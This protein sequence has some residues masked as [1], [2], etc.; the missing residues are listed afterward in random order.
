MVAIRRQAEAPEPKRSLAESIKALLGLDVVE[1]PKP[2]P[3]KKTTCVGGQSLYQFIYPRNYAPHTAQKKAHGPQNRAPLPDVPGE[4]VEDRARREHLRPKPIRF[5]VLCCGRR[6]GKT[7][8]SAA[9]FVAN[10]VADIEDKLLG[11]GRWQGHPH[12]P[13]VRT[14]GKDPEPFLRYF[15]ISPTHALNDEPK[16]ALRKYFGHKDDTE[17]GLIVEQLEKPSVW[18]LKGGVR[19]DFLSADRPLLNVSHGYHGGWLDECARIKADLWENNLR[20][21]L[22][23]HNGWAI[24]S[25][26]PLGRNWFWE[27]IWAHGDRRAAELLARMRGVEAEQILDEAQFAC[28]SWTTADNDAIPGLKAEMELARRQLSDANFRRNYLADFEAFEGQCFDLDAD[29]MAPR[30]QPGMAWRA[31]YGGFDPGMRHRAAFSIAVELPR[32]KGTRGGWSEID[33]DSA[34]GVLPYGDE[35]WARRDRGDRSTW[36]NRAYH[37]LKAVVG[38]RWTDVPIYM[39]ADAAALAIGQEWERYG[40]R[41]EHAFQEHEPAV[42]WMQTALKNRRF[43]LRTEVQWTCMTTLRFPGPGEKSTKLWIDKN[44]DE[45]DALR[46]AL[47]EPISKGFSPLADG[48]PLAALGWQRH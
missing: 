19:I 14:P 18:W 46:Y 11:R 12:E 15:V 36:A 10:I 17:P 34:S 29:H 48:A 32:G 28:V 22:S 7:Q 1:R 33:T 16:I 35:A 47:T 5:L 42:T 43:T 38:D 20:A 30:W 41:I 9:Q 2:D 23:D 31:I 26:T 25:T 21:A 37:A 6:G 24:F 39:P 40:F 45:W 8:A 3:P 4:S 13:W 27:S 44:D